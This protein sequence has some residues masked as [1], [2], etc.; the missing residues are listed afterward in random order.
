M[1][2]AEIIIS[3]FNAVIQSRCSP[4]ID[5]RPWKRRDIISGASHSTTG[6]SGSRKD[7]VSVFKQQHQDV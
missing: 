6:E 7:Q 4:P 3:S 5:P 2:E 1:R